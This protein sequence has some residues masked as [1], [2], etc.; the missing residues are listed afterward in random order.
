MVD[1]DKARLQYDTEN[2]LH[3]IKQPGAGGAPIFDVNW[4]VIGMHQA[5]AC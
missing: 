3:N 2:P 5:P 4:R 1:V